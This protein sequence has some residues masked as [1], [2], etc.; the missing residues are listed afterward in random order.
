MAARTFPAVFSCLTFA[1]LLQGVEH[2]E[3]AGAPGVPRGARCPHRAYQASGQAFARHETLILTC[4]SFKACFVSASPA[5]WHSLHSQTGAPA[6]AWLASQAGLHQAPADA[7]APHSSSVQPPCPLV[8]LQIITPKS[9]GM[10]F[11]AIEAC[12]ATTKHVVMLTTVP[13][14]YP[15]VSRVCLRASSLRHPKRLAWIQY[16]LSTLFCRV[17]RRELSSSKIS[18]HARTARVAAGMP[19]SGLCALFCF[20]VA[21]L[22]DLVP[23][24]LR[25]Q[26]RRLTICLL[27]C[28]CLGQRPC[29]RPC[30]GQT[31]CSTR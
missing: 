2:G 24:Q 15:N 22:T 18:Y 30:P 10:I 26:G 21:G 1:V 9:W 17:A 28:R 29:W 3:A 23:G 20:I 7:I 31:R 8:C 14:V 19:F 13:V 25:G 4:L 6:A 11:D 12:P 27:S 16:F 5:W